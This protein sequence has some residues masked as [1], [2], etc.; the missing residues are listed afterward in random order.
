MKRII[1][2]LLLCMMLTACL[3]TPEVELIA[4]K[5]SDTNETVPFVSLDLPQH[6]T[7]DAGE[8]GGAHLSIDAD[9]I[10]P[11]QASFGV[12]EVH[13]KR[14]DRETVANLTEYFADGRPLYLQWEDNKAELYQKLL[15]FEAIANEENE[16]DIAMLQYLREAFENAPTDVE[17]IPFSTESIEPKEASCSLYAVGETGQSS[18]F[19]TDTLFLYDRDSTLDVTAQSGVYPDDPLERQTPRISREDAEKAA[20]DCIDALHIEHVGLLEEQVER[21]VFF[22]MNRTVE[23]GYRFLFTP[24][25]G[26]INCCCS[27][28]WEMIDAVAPSVGAPWNCE[29]ID[30]YVGQDGVMEFVWSF[31]G[32]YGEPDTRDAFIAFDR[33]QSLIGNQLLYLYSAKASQEQSLSNLDARIAYDVT[34]DRIG[35]V[36]GTIQK[37]DDLTVGLNVPL[38]EVCY[39]VQC[40]GEPAIAQR[41]YFDASDGTYVEPRISYREL[42]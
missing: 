27:G 32:A 21:C 16:M 22:R 15:D 8:L 17:H 30:I 35:L 24:R 5:E 23:W 19:F 36:R 13:E 25:I 26:N 38:W 40:P 11:E 41:I 7:A 39:T 34:I 42:M 3:P 37:K 6:I 29:W 18:L 4:Q 31:P 9:V 33:M 1:A 14:F 2:V 12:S 10:V 20:R 28:D